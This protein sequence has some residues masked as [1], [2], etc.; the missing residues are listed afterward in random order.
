[1]SKKTIYP[2]ADPGFVEKGSEVAEGF[3]AQWIQGKPWWGSIGRRHFY[4]LWTYNE[5]NK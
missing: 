4:E 3:E 1:M 5:N 2:V